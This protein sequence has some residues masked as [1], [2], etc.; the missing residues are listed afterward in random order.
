[1]KER[2]LAGAVPWDDALPPPEV[3][4]LVPQ[5]EPGR[6]LDLGCGYGRA[7]IFMVRH[8]WQV[9][10]VDFIP[11]A[12]AEAARRAE[13]A[14]VKG[15]VCF[16]L[17]RVSELDFLNGRY[18]FA[19]DVGCM[20]SLDESELQNYAAG[21]RRL[22]RPGATYLLYARLAE[23]EPGLDKGPRGIPEQTVKTLF[24]NGFDLERFIPGETT[25]EDQPV[26]SSAW[27]YFR[28]KAD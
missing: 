22:L 3:V 19:L 9:D 10:G 14:G 11:D 2:Y 7:T 17:G 6:A 4:E 20:H 12:I 23:P 21:L 5:L 13:A 18:D 25:V 15:Q 8:G 16:H 28:R 1:M 27:F 24:A 26:W